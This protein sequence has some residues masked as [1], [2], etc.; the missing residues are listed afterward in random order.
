[1]YS[2]ITTWR[3]HCFGDFLNPGVSI[4]FLHCKW[5]LHTDNSSAYVDDS[6]N[7]RS[8]KDGATEQQHS[9]TDSSKI[10]SQG[11]MNTFVL[12]IFPK[13]NTH[14]CPSDG[15]L[16][17]TAGKRTD[18][19]LQLSQSEKEYWQFSCIGDTKWVPVYLAAKRQ[20]PQKFH[21][22][23]PAVR[24]Q[25]DKFCRFW[26]SNFRTLFFF[27][28]EIPRGRRFWVRC[29]WSALRGKAQPPLST[30]QWWCPR[31]AAKPSARALCPVSAICCVYQVRETNR[32]A[33]SS[34]RYTWTSIRAYLAEMLKVHVGDDFQ[35][36][37]SLLHIF[38]WILMEKCYLSDKYRSEVHKVQCAW[39][40]HG[41][42]VSH[43]PPVSHNGSSKSANWW[44]RNHKT[45][46]P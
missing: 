12:A 43:T 4:A 1:M 19:R 36:N 10:V 31:N 13:G 3:E 28:K 45:I 26:V 7:Q 24:S 33:E 15:S 6:S 25:L 41:I 22:L 35:L 34:L 30:G 38:C 23:S 14:S 16:L 42:E 5:I 39:T 32:F 8:E 20:M 2:R 9:A 40:Q 27:V 37:K 11:H 44:K 18:S 29:T 17:R 46:Y 21:S